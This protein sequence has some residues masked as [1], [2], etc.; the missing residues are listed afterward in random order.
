MVDEEVVEDTVEDADEAL[1][2]PDD[3]DV[4]AEGVAAAPDEAE[5]ESLAEGPLPSADFS[6][7]VVAGAG[8]LVLA[9]PLSPPP[10]LRK[11]VTYQPDPLS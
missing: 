2:V 6:A 10:L 3:V 11:S 1:A 9:P 7:A 5:D 8:S 4:D